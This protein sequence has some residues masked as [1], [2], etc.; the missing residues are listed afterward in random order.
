MAKHKDNNTEE[1]ILKAA[2]E[3]FQTKGLDGSRMQ[4]IAD[5]ANINKAMLHYYYRSKQLLFEAVFKK[6]F[7]LL[8]PELNAILN[9]DSSVEEK[10]QN[11][12]FNYINFI[13]KHPYI[14]NFV[15]H[16][17]NKNPTFIEKLQQ[18]IAF[19]NIDKFKA[20]VKKEIE[21][22]NI[23]PIDPDQ[24][25]INILSLNVFPFIGA[26][27]FKAI[28]KKDNEAYNQLLKERKHSVSNFIINAIK[29]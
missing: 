9:D 1:S 17:L 19:P 18:N 16:E 26:P 12:T 25:F 10:I 13:T 20:T 24:L 4:E 11:F 29:K 6:A 15:I 23:K 2:N 5:K 21:E 8:A 3:V 28:T 14:P 27:L 7:S 22:G